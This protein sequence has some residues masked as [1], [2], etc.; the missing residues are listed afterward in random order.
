MMCQLSRVACS[1]SAHSFPL[2]LRSSPACSLQAL[3]FLGAKPS[4]CGAPEAHSRGGYLPP[5]PGRQ[6][7]NCAMQYTVR[8]ATAAAPSTAEHSSVPL[9]SACKQGHCCHQSPAAG[10]RQVA[11]QDAALQPVLTVPP[12]VICLLC[13]RE[14]TRRHP[15][16]ARLAG[17]SP[18]AGGS[19][20]RSAHSGCRQYGGRCGIRRCDDGNR[21]PAGCSSSSSSSS[22]GGSGS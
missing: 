6:A 1:E 15:E 22:G 20:G 14:P 16:Q 13:C 18:E 4:S 3:S 12:K 9:A 21:A 19:D 8:C 10:L 7:L 17:S 2:T 5:P 11:S